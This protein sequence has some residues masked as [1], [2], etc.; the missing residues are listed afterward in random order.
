MQGG[1]TNEEWMRKENDMTRLFTMLL[2]ILLIGTSAMQVFI[3]DFF[4]WP[5]RCA[6]AFL[7]E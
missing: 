6:C 7:T 3:E 5:A 2:T 1:L 4:D